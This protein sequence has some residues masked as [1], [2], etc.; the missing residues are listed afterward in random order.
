MPLM[1]GEGNTDGIQ[2]PLFGPS[3]DGRGVS[4]RTRFAL[5]RSMNGSQH[6]HKATGDS[7]RQDPMVWYQRETKT[8]VPNV[9]SFSQ[10]RY[11]VLPKVEL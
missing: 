6:I 9:V 11:I 7:C 1:H 2:G 4:H 8:S 3:C 10:A 5:A